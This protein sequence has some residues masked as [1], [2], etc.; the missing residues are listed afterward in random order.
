MA[1][2]S[3]VFLFF[4]GITTPLYFIIPS[5]F[6]RTFLIL[7]SLLFC[8]YLIPWHT[9]LLFFIILLNFF[10]GK[11][12][13]DLKESKS[14]VILYSIISIDVGILFIFKYFDFFNLGLSD[15]ANLIGWNYSARTLNLILPLGIS[16]YTFKNV[17]YNIEVHRQTIK[18]EG[19]FDVYFL[20]ITIYP[21]M[22]AGPIDRPQ[23]LLK[24]I[25]EWH[26]FEYVRVTNGLKLMAW[27][28]FLKWVIADRL[29]PLVAKIYDHPRGNPIYG[30]SLATF[31]F[32]IQIYCDFAGYSNIAIG[33]GQV[34]GFDFC[35]N[36][37]RPYF[38]KSISEFWSRWHISLTSWLRDYVFLPVAYKVLRILKNKTFMSVRPENWS[39]ITATL[40][41]MLI[42][43]IWHGANWTFIC[44]GMLIGIYL[45]FSF[46]T[47]NIR[48]KLWNFMRLDKSHLIQKI[49]RIGI[50]FTLVSLAWVFFRANS[51]NDAIFIIQNLPA[52]VYQFGKLLIDSMIS[53]RLYAFVQCL[54]LGKNEMES[55]Q[56]ILFISVFFVIEVV[57][58]KVDIRDAISRRPLFIRWAIYIGLIVVILIYG[59]FETRQFIYQQF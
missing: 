53:F 40:T 55:Y 41:T 6:Q 11:L 58:R 20:Y 12:I 30:L 44:W 10:S 22:F 34:L 8:S 48:R 14:K 27:G 13:E 47:K 4:F 32:A 42:A 50:T 56:I 2:N 21:E 43:G 39:Y 59:R 19:R 24:Q 46:L 57:E 38:A 9:L 37:K 36:F 15:F 31:Y 23:N 3:L 29:A 26:T 45:L 52:S 33:A 16:F 49:V 18:A 28:Y 54:S 7:A 1:F 17:C 5:R 35:S 25:V 51:L